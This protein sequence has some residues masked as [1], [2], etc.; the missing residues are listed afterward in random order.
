[1]E[2]MNLSYKIKMCKLMV[3]HYDDIYKFIKNTYEIKLVEIV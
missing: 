1:M 2:F 3:K